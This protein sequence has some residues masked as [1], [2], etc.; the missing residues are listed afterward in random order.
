MRIETTLL[1]PALIALGACANLGTN[2]QLVVDGPRSAAF[3]S[4]LAQCRALVRD[5]GQL[6]AETGAAAV[7]G[8]GVGALAGLVDDDMTPSEAAIGGAL[9]GAA[10]ATAEN[11]DKRQDMV[12]NC[13]IGR[14]HKVIG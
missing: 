4:D 6:E 9:G 8:A 1:L 3:D 2:E 13:M 14:G 11:A 10:F 5:Q 12:I 7:L